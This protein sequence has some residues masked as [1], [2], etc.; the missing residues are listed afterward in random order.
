[1]KSATEDNSKEPEWFLSFGLYL[2]RQQQKS[3]SGNKSIHRLGIKKEVL[4]QSGTKESQNYA[5]YIHNW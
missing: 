2:R 5:E 1:M 3:A 4:E